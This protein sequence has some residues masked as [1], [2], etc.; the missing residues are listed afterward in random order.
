ASLS[1]LIAKYQTCKTCASTGS[2]PVDAG[3]ANPLLGANLTGVWWTAA[4]RKSQDCFQWLKWRTKLSAGA[5]DSPHF[6]HRNPHFSPAVAL[7]A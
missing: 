7:Q 1:S 3:C 4:F 2:I 5:G 6:I